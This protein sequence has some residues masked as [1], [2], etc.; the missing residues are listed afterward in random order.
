MDLLSA[1]I[2]VGSFGRVLL[3]IKLESAILSSYSVFLSSILVYKGTDYVEGDTVRF[4]SHNSFNGGF[5]D[6]EPGSYPD[7]SKAPLNFNNVISSIQVH[8]D[9]PNNSSLK[10]HM[11]IRIFDKI[12][13]Q[14]AYRDIIQSVPD[15]KMIGFDNTVSSLQTFAGPDYDP[16]YLCDFYTGLNYTGGMLYPGRIGPNVSIPDLEVGPYRLEDVI[17]SI[18]ISKRV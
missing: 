18:E 2:K 11:V 1:Q 14:G 8:P 17:S 10:V 3:K 7:L 6:L 15:L 5:I 9:N 16:E 4:F 12:N 13:Y